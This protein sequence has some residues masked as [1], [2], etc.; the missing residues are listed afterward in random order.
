MPQP[1]Q[2]P[3]Q[4]PTQ[5]P[6]QSPAQGQAP[7]SDWQTEN[8]PRGIKIYTHHEQE[9]KN[10]FI[11]IRISL[12][13]FKIVKFMPKSCFFRQNFVQKTVFL[14]RKLKFQK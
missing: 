3:Q 5:A 11:Y 14:T 12:E 6:Q 10:N 4:A 13:K 7:Q 8:L 1:T 9:L 2:A